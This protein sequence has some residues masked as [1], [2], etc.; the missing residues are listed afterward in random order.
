MMAHK[1]NVATITTLLAKVAELTEA[2][3]KELQSLPAPCAYAHPKTWSLWQEKDTAILNLRPPKNEGLPIEVLHPAFATFVHDIKTMQP[4]EWTA[5]VDTNKVSITLCNE[6]AKDFPNEPDRRT[7][8]T[9]QLN[10][11]Q[12]ALRVEYHI[13]KTLPMEAHSVRPD[14][15]LQVGD[16]T[17][18][19]GV[20]KGEVGTTGD[21]YMH[22]SR[23]YQ[24]LVNNLE[25][26]G[27]ASAG[28][29]CILLVVHGLWSA[30]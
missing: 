3:Q 5:E 12:L 11:L 19:L 16:M 4:N 9:D 28:V 13:Q 1:S 8:L 15:G 29:P 21:A 22:V 27:K 26:K 7:V 24:A 25:G 23:S 14:I 20:V 2:L 6:M 10:R 18:L 30:S 17:V